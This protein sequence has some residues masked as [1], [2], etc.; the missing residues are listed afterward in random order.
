[1]TTEKKL[2]AVETTRKSFRFEY[3]APVD[4]MRDGE[5]FAYGTMLNISRG[6]AA[7]RSYV[8][9]QMGAVYKL[10]IR[11]VGD[12]PVTVVRRFN[13]DCYA[14]RFDVEEAV[15]RRIDKTLAAIF[16]PDG[17]PVAEKARFSA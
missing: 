10:H 9:L 16:D 1:M 8:P 17:A 7:F 3:A 15:K 12:F 11:G 2:D 13:G 4:V 6:G 5:R 14:A